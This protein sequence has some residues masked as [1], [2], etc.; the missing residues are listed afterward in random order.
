[1]RLSL[2]RSVVCILHGAYMIGNVIATLPFNLV[3]VRGVSERMRSES[4]HAKAPISGDVAEILLTLHPVGKQC[5]NSQQ[6]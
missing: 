3:C 5:C 6:L 1:M 4:P 2:S